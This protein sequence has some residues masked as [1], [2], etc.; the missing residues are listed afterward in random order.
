VKH[1]ILAAIVAAC[2]SGLIAMA[3]SMAVTSNQIRVV[4]MAMHGGGR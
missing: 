4:Y 1:I 2:F 3:G